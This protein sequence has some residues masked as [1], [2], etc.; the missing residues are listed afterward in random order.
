MAWN[1][2][3]DLKKIG[4][5]LKQIRIERNLTIGEVAKGV[6]MSPELLDQLE[7]GRC[8]DCT[9]DTIFKLIDYYVTSGEEVFVKSGI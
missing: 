2:V 1:I 7:E 4:A 8:P 5:S 3:A 6:K 9:L